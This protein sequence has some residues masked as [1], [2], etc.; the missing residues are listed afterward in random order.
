MVVMERYLDLKANQ[1]FLQLQAQLEGTEN[2]INVSRQRYNGTVKKY[3]TFIRRYWKR[4]LLGWIVEE[5]EFQEKEVF[6]AY[7]GAEKA[8]KVQF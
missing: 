3:N 1:N 4:T 5:G 7:K 8:P 6:E 2:R